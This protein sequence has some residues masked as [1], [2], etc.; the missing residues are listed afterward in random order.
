MRRGR[1]KWAPPWFFG[2]NVLTALAH[3]PYVGS[4]VGF[5]KPWRVLMQSVPQLQVTEMAFG[6]GYAA[7]GQIRG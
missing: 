4:F 5:D 7:V 2:L 3:R 6:A 1:A